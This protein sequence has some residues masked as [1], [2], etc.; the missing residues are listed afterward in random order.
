MITRTDLRRIARARLQDSTILFNNRRYDGA[1]YLCGYVI[2]VAL[3]ARIVT[4]L[5][6]QNGYPMTRAEFKDLG[7]FKTHNLEIL[8]KLAGVEQAIKTAHLA[9]WSIVVIW[10]PEVRYRPIGT[11]TR[12]DAQNMIQATTNLIRAI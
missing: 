3:K 11:A 12:A 4:T 10:D 1:V 9:D 6:W 7:N 5:R 8:L 2:E